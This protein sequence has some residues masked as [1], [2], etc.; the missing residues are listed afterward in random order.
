MRTVVVVF[1]GSNCDRDV[2]VALARCTGRSPDLVW[3]G[4][5]SLPACDLVVLP[6]GFSYGDYLRAG[7]IAAHSPVMRSVHEAAKRGTAVLGICNGFQILTE[8]GLL[9]GALVR[10]AGLRFVCRPVD[11]RV[12]GDSPFLAAFTPGECVRF[13][14]AHMEGNYQAAAETVA[15]LEGDGRVTLRY[16]DEAGCA[17]EAANPNGSAAGI[18]AITSTNRRIFGLMPHPERVIGSELGGSDGRRFFTA[19]ADALA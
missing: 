8:T 11:L 2:A 16:V 12:D 3:H 13:P 10:N 1:P 14:V 9:P 15:R 18:A 6:G 4:A 19:L 7:A 5:A 17:T